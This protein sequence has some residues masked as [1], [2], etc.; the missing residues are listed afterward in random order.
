MS[1]KKEYPLEIGGVIGAASPSD[2]PKTAGA[3]PKREY[4]VS[5]GGDKG[6]KG[7]K[8]DNEKIKQGEAPKGWVWP[9]QGS[10]H[11]LAEKRDNP[12]PVISHSLAL[13]YDDAFEINKHNV[14]ESVA[15]GVDALVATYMYEVLDT[16]FAVYVIT[17]NGK[18]FD[19]SLIPHC[20]IMH[21][22]D[23]YRLYIEKKVWNAHFPVETLPDG[24]LYYR[25]V[26]VFRSNDAQIGTPLL[27]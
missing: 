14:E 13:T 20:F 6:D 18:M 12:E 5:A 8:G 10:V 22:E 21:P 24:E 1:G 4:V 19:A 7:D 17:V 9:P 16:R 26:R 27:F 15:L 23:V 25:Q 2:D 11:A 3:R